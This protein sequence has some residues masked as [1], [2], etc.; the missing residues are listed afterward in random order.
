M[1][2]LQILCSKYL[3]LLIFLICTNS[4]A[5]A[6]PYPYLEK[7]G[8]IE[9]KESEG[10]LKSTKPMVDEIYI[11]SKKD[12]LPQQKIKAL[13]YQSKIEIITEGGKR[14]EAKLYN[15]FKEEIQAAAATIER[16]ILQSLL[17]E[18]LNEY[19][20][21]HRYQ[22]SNRTNED[23]TSKND[24]FLTWS[25][26]AYKKEITTLYDASIV[27]V[28]QL[29]REPI[30]N[31]IFILDTAEQYRELRPTIFDLLAHRAISYYLA[32]NGQERAE[33]VLGILLK[34]HGSDVS[35]NAYLYN[36]LLNIKLKTKAS[37]DSQLAQLKA[38]S[39][40]NPEAWYTA[41]ILLQLANAYQQKLSAEPKERYAERKRYADSILYICEQANEVYLATNGNKQLQLIKKN[42]LAPEISIQTE[43]FSIPKQPIPVYLAHKNV[44]KI[45]VKV[46][47]YK[48]SI[49]GYLANEFNAWRDIKKQQDV[50]SLLKIYPEVESYTITLK[51]FDD[52]DQHTT[53]A[54]FNAL[55]DGEYIALISNN[56][57]FKFDSV[58]TILFQ[59]IDV[60]AN[61]LV[62][63]E[64]ELLLTDRDS[65]HPIPKSEIAIYE[66][67]GNGKDLQLLEKLVTNENGRASHSNNK[68]PLNGSKR[69]VYQVKGDEVF[70]D[71]HQYFYSANNT[72][73]EDSQTLKV[74]FFTDRGI[75]R[76]GQTVY[77]KG[78]IYKETKGR[79]QTVGGHRAKIHLYD[80]N[81][82]KVATTELTSNQFGSVFG[83]F[84]LPMGKATGRYH[85]EE[86]DGDKEIAFSVE[87]YKRPTFSV[88]MDT[89]KAQYKIGDSIVAKGTARAYSGAVISAAK[90]S[91]RVVRNSVYPYRSWLLS[92]PYFPARSEEIAVGK[93][94]TNTDGRFEIPFQ[95][96]AADEK[97]AGHYRFYNYTLEVS[98]TDINGETRQGNQTIMVGDKSVMLQVSL[99]PSINID[100]LDSISFR[101]L[102]LN[103]QSVSAKG[104]IRLTK[105]KAPDRILRPVPFSETDY[106]LMDSLSYV[107]NFPY[108]PFGTEEDVERW[109]KSQVVMD[110]D[111]NSAHQ[112]SVM[113]EKKKELEAGAY[114][115]AAYVLDGQDTLRTTQV[116]QAYH[117]EPKKPVDRE[118]LRVTTLKPQYKPGEN[119]IIIFSSA[120][121]HATILIE[122][123]QNGKIIRSENLILNNEVKQFEFPITEQQGDKLFLHYYM[124]KYNA[125]ESGRLEIGIQQ[126]ATDLTVTTSTFRDKLQPGKEEIWELNISGPAKDKVFAEVLATMYDASLDQFAQHRLY[127]SPAFKDTYSKIPVWN[128]NYAYG[129]NYGSQLSLAGKYD[130]LPIIRYEDLKHFGFSFANEGWKQRRYVSKL[131]PRS[132]RVTIEESGVMDFNA[133]AAVPTS[134][135][136]QEVVVLGYGDSDMKQDIAGSAGGM[137]IRGNSSLPA[138]VQPL[139]VVDGEI[140]QGPLTIKPADIMSVQVL[141]AEA[142]AL[143]GARGANGVIIITTKKAV[144]TALQG[145]KARTNLKETAFFYPDLKTDAAGNIKIRFTTPESLTEWKFMALAHT[146]TLETGYLEQSVRTTKDLMVVPNA[147]RFLREGDE[148]V[149]STKIINLSDTDLTG[150]AKLMLFDAYTMQPVDSLYASTESTR[151]FE[152]KKGASTS[153]SW[154]LKIPASQLLVYRI[155]ATAG[156]FTDG[157]EAVLP[158]LPNKMLVTETL[159]LYAKEGQTKRFMMQALAE[160]SKE[161]I[162]GRLTLELTSNPM[163]YAIQALPYLQEY[164]YDCSEQLFAKLY[165]TLV[166][167]RLMDASPKIKVIFDDWNKKGLLQSKLETNQELKSVLLEETPWVRESENEE[168]KMK[169]LALLFDVNN[170]RNQWQ[171]T[172]QKFAARQ[173]SSGGFS[174]FEGG[175]ANMA[176]TTHIVA[177]FGHLKNMKIDVSD[178]GDSSY[179]EVLYKAIQYL[180]KEA[181]KSLNNK[182]NS[183]YT[184]V[185]YLYARSYFL[186]EYPLKE[187]I[188]KRILVSLDKDPNE[189]V[190]DN[191]QEKAMLSL[192]Y[193]RYGQ[194][195]KS[196][197]IISSLRDYAVNDDEMGM[198]WKEN[199]S[200]WNWWQSP[201]ETQAFLIEAFQEVA[202]DTKGVEQMKLWLLK[203]KQTN[204]WN[205]TKATTEAI[206]ALLFTGKDWLATG[207]GLE[208]KLGNQPIDLKG[209]TRAA[210]YIKTSWEPLA[211][212]SDMANVEIAKESPGPVWGALYWQHFEKLT[213]IKAAATGVQLEKILYLKENTDQGPVLKPIIPL[214]PLKVGDLITVKLIIRADRD[215]QF[216]HLK[217]MRASG[218]E[219]VNVLSSF[220]LQNGLGYYESTRDVTTN[221]FIDRVPKGTYVF[222]YDVRANNAGKF[223]NGISTIQS[224]YAPEMSAHSEGVPVNIKEIN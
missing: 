70:F 81:N 110:K 142:S 157:E 92:K 30:G 3:F 194:L 153:L 44:N 84:T 197:K 131:S 11:Q 103:G 150:S 42:I 85:L 187:D 57:S 53:I 12:G 14:Q 160:A 46:L 144:E 149:L 193:H 199:K 161:T 35:K 219:P 130:Y 121:P 218:F 182:E 87:E 52:Y 155:A 190:A 107:Q 25:E 208:V 133:V 5:N 68:L 176:I 23:T 111:F 191:L 28:K 56:E 180:D 69:W 159:P 2:H 206:Y 86:E 200:G 76:P 209:S 32:N 216:V 212:K 214:T 22:I 89:V 36:S 58:N 141:K 171:S 26:A 211:I 189:R 198:Y 7:W 136:L 94:N 16:S 152:T 138:G 88:V 72:K 78:I 158:V 29:Q 186:K 120:L 1:K 19:F 196:R 139:Y 188:K 205:S 31:W 213:S 63:K 48:K 13:L 128:T 49:S 221:F 4:V 137:Q 165:S 38:L 151:S 106:M 105:L 97:E 175:E 65:G 82:E 109:P 166:S 54:K 122:L 148:L 184:L 91:Y 126:R 116:V 47:K 177:G 207:D 74:Q 114:L 185:R 55:D 220:K 112:Q 146:T 119:A 222:E 24:D 170:L 147:P 215:L 80:P 64:G 210:G 174:W 135:G 71:T 143:Y 73:Q 67:S 183:V 108:I 77:F 172:Y 178:L 20:Q 115:L 62:F 10:L 204:H 124:G 101:T 203:N 102:N 127:F 39:R 90:V 96:K 66:P 181:L 41:E 61:S 40:L 118:F 140:I 162:H 163:W 93:V 201:I 134:K 132:D 43:R 223:S 50:D 17:A 154:H 9:K 8:E 123:E 168:I 156:N 129:V 60:S 18:L 224:M 179:Q 27:N 169:R 100:Q 33:D 164:P 37:D 34:Q 167:K 6:Q 202:Q 75:Y 95:A 192:V 59:S 21:Q 45:Y 145:V 51:K 173:L 117:S 15:R 113:L 104:N 195:Q 79:R 98:V 217:D 83:N 99:P 125:V